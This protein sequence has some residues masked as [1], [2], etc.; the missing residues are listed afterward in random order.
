MR[1]FQLPQRFERVVRAVVLDKDY[2][3]WTNGLG[4]ERPKRFLDLVS[5]VEAR[6]HYGDAVAVDPL[7]TRREAGGDP[8]R[9]WASQQPP[10][11]RPQDDELG[12]P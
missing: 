8:N 4:Q 10:D 5:G 2:F 7:G 1:P 12:H 11:D 9:Q 3:D 6:H